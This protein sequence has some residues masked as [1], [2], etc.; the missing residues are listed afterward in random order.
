VNKAAA[1][2]TGR[3]VSKTNTWINLHGKQLIT[4]V[5]Q[6]LPEASQAPLRCI[7]WQYGD[8]GR[9]MLFTIEDTETGKTYRL[10][11]EIGLK[12]LEIFLNDVI[13]GKLPGLG[14]GA[15]LMDAGSYDAYAIDCLVQYCIFG[16]AIYG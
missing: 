6:N 7:N 1:F 13:S 14:L 12:G 2:V 5:F 15:A 3:S 9:P 8:D 16:K 10:D 11:E 4:E